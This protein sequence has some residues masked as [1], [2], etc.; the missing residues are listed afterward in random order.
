MVIAGDVNQAP[1]AET[2]RGSRGRAAV[3]NALHLDVGDE[4]QVAGPSAG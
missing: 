3:A 1:S 4:D 2:S